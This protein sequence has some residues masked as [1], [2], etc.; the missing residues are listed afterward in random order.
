MT[1]RTENTTQKNNELNKRHKI[2]NSVLCLL[3]IWLMALIFG[4]SLLYAVKPVIPTANRHQKGKIFLEYA[5]SLSLNEM[6]PEYQVLSGHVKFRKG[7]M[8]MYCDSAHFYD[9]EN[10]MNAFGNVKMEQGDT[11]FVY[12]DVLYYDG[13]QE[14]ARLRKVQN[15]VRLE[16][17]NTT[18]FTD[19]LDYDLIANIGYYFKG[20]EISD[21][22]NTITSIYGQYA[23]DTK[24]SEFL[25]D[26]VLTNNEKK[27]VLN[28]D[29]LLYNTKTHIADIVGH[30]TIESDSSI[31]YTDR[32]WYN[33]DK[34]KVQLLNRSLIVGKDGQTLTGDTIVYDRANGFGEVFG[35]MVLTDTAKSAVLTGGYGYHNEK[36]NT[37]FA[38]RRALAMEYSQGDTVFVHGDTIRTYLQMPDSSRVMRLPQRAFLPHRCAR[39]VRLVDISV[40][41]LNDIHAPPPDTLESRATSDGQRHTDTSERQHSRQSLSAG[42]WTDGRTRGRGVL[43]PVVGKRNDCNIH[44]RQTPPP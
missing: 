14:I 10:K 16:H 3:A 5:D 23:P 25:Y 28:T 44:R 32:G 9:K 1:D 2:L 38:T 11:L 17:R 22:K 13:M 39:S 36:D 34:D 7:D 8:Y 4:D 18:L 41:R 43:Q 21:D 37:S 29:T 42:I 24:D 31:V 6:H 35:N 27:F 15:G 33:T 19:S 30:T 40:A 12:S 20:G 26:V